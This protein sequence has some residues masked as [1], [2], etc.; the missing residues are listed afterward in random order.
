MILVE[1]LSNPRHATGAATMLLDFL[2]LG[3]HLNLVAKEDRRLE[4]PL[5][6]TDQGQRRRVGLGTAQASQHAQAKQSVGNGFTKRRSVSVFAVER[7]VIPG[8]L[9]KAGDIAG[10]DLPPPAQPAV[11]DLQVFQIQRLGNVRI[12]Q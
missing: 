4:L 2:D 9:S 3:E 5:G 12:S 1:Q 10:G 11:P 7:I 6:D 8:Q